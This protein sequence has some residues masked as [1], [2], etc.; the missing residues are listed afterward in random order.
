MRNK[1][2][3]NI[4]VAVLIFISILLFF[5]TL[6]LPQKEEVAKLTLNDLAKG[7]NENRV[8]RIVVE[9]EIIKA[10]FID[11][12]KGETKKEVE[13][14][15]SETLRNFGVAPEKLSQ[16]PIEIKE[17]SS[18]KFWA[19]ILLPSLI[20]VIIIGI[21]FW[22]TFRQARSGASQ[23]FNFGKSNIR[24]FT[25]FKDRITFADVAGL[26]EAKQELME[27]VDFLKN[28]KKY[29][30]L[31]AQIPRG[32]LLL[33]PPGTGKTLMARAVAGEAGV[34]FF[35]ISASEFVEMFVGVGASRTRDAFATAK[36]AAPS[37][38]FIDEIDAVGRERGAGLG[39]GHDEREQ[40]LNQILVEMDG[41]EKDAQVIVLAATNRPDILDPALLRPGR[42]D[43]RVVLDLPDLSDREEILKIHARNKP[44]AANVDLR[45]VAIRTPGF[46][47]AELANLVN[48]AAILAARK[49]KNKI[50]QIELYEAIEKVLLGP[51]RRS[52]VLSKKEKEITA[53]HEAGHALVA[54]CLKHADPVH[55]VSII[56]RGQAGGY[57]L[58]LPSEDIYL[59]TRKQFLAD[60]AI[61]FGGYSAEEITFGDISTGA[62]NDLQVASEMARKLVTKYGMSEKFGPLT[63]G[64]TQELIFLGKEITTEKNYS[65]AIAY[66]IDKEVEKLIQRSYQAAKKIIQKKKGVLEFIAKTL[67]EKETIEKDEFE[68][69]IKKF[70][71]KKEEIS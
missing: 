15:L 47:G 51:E 1:I 9:G 70:K 49:G 21:F 19:S 2:V 10:T 20:P 40:T 5:S 8:S 64:K 57:T 12:K 7:I 67:I 28:P 52:R 30:D 43:R 35:H 50:E 14:S 56:A 68:E 29:L 46:S 24:L 18:L 38:L 48:E 62:S 13:T 39:G 36:R 59:R 58:K 6:S 37:I 31:G 55:K 41:F 69:I 34:P 66:E 53:Y 17:E 11:G 23:V 65:D 54:A 22:L 16:I 4:L 27:I 33:G 3:K 25:P 60:M 63:F 45:Q 26:K 42:F 44:L 71:I 32:V 61:M